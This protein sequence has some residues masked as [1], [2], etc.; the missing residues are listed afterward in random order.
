MTSEL[1]NLF[2]KELEKAQNELRKSKIRQEQS[3]KALNNKLKEMRNQSSAARKK[4]SNIMAR[5]LPPSSH[6]SRRPAAIL[7]PIHGTEYLFKSFPKNKKRKRTHTQLYTTSVYN[8]SQILHNNR[9][10]N[11][12]HSLLLY[13]KNAKPVKP[14]KK[15]KI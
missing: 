6:V 7:P 4:H 2:K 8:G 3:Q 1:N 13:N 9:P 11:A 12:L 15:R 14:R 10:T 5:L